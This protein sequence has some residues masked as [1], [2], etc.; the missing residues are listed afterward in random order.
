MSIVFVNCFE[1]PAGAEAEFFERWEVVNRFMRTQPGYV[2]HV[3]Y[4]AKAPDT[5]FRFVNTAV[6]ESA[7]ALKTAHGPKF[8]ELVSG[9][10]WERFT[11]YPGVF[12]P[13]HTGS[14]E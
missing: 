1:V 8:R 5:R 7:E 6:W 12:E 11:S 13:I 3:L 4:R 10:E 2:S 14:A 9:P